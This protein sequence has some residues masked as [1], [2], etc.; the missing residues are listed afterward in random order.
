LNSLFTVKY[1]EVNKR[2]V[3]LIVLL[4]TAVSVQE[5]LRTI[6]FEELT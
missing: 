5:V 1:V 6:N 3:F 2:D 4:V